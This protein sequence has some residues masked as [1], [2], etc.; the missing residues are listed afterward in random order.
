MDWEDLRHFLA[1]ADSGS[2][3]GAARALSVDHS[4]VARRIAALEAALDL[5]LVERQPRA[6]TLT[7]DGRRLAQA[8]HHAA[9]A[10]M[11]VRRVAASASPV[12]AG[13]VSV[14]APP[15]FTAAVLAPLIPALRQAHPAL[16]VSLLGAVSA[17]D[18]G[19][20][21][22]DIALRLSR[23]EIPGLVVR[24]VAPVPFAF[25]AAVGFERPAAAWAFIGA[26]GGS[27]ALP[28]FRWLDDQLAG[29]PVV[30]RTNDAASQAALARAGVGVALL[31]RFLGDRDSSLYRLPSAASCPDRELWMLVHEDLRKTPRIRAVLNYLQPALRQALSA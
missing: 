24:K 26:D 30:A 6:V 25:Y 12:I 1:L 31:P 17:A 10:M 21:Q 28:Q 20:R 23:P 4:T 29:R 9:E 7:A 16:V 15:A 8:G 5:R 13:P 14:S 18:L 22:A 11:A 2:L 27:R 3:S 19:H